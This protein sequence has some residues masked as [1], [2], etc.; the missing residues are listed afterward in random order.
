MIRLNVKL[1]RSAQTL[2][3]YVN[4]AIGYRMQC[5]QAL[6]YSENCYGHADTISFR[7][8]FLRIHDLKTGLIAGSMDQLKIYAALFCLEYG[9]KPGLIKI[10]LRIYQNDEVFAEIPEVDEIAHIMSRIITFDD[11]IEQAKAGGLRDH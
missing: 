7:D 6:F 9:Y 11:L 10:E 8:D 3:R 5:E 4:D 1:P 2:N